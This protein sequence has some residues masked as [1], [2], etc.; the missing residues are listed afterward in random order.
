M[1]LFGTLTAWASRSHSGAFIRSKTAD[2][3]PGR[4]RSLRSISC[5]VGTRRKARIGTALH[6]VSAWLLVILLTWEFAWQ[7]DRAVAGSGSWPA[8]AWAHCPGRCAISVAEAAV[9]TAWPVG[10][11]AEG[12]VAIAG[13]GIAV[14]L[15]MWSLLTNLSMRGDPHPLPYVPLLNPLDLAQAF[16]LLVLIRYWLHLQK[17]RYPLLQQLTWKQA[18][19][20]LAALAFVWLNA[21][22]LRTLHHWAG[23]PFELDRMLTS[24]LVQTSLSI[25]WTVLALATMVLATRYA[26]RIVWIAGVALLPVVILKLLFVDLSRVGTVERIVSFVVVGVLFLVVGYF[27]PVP[28]AR[29]ERA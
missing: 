5:A 3:S 25:F 19:A 20:T 21:V 16:V 27:S 11:H 2:G 23:V 28:P 17:E 22:L 15:M 1:V 13:G 8:I 12:Y 14:A 6:V 24:T 29:E 26:S 9:E 7:V 18:A 10:A 4:S